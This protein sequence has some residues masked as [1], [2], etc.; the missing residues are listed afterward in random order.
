MPYRYLEALQQQ[1]DELE[2]EIAK[3]GAAC[4]IL[5][6]PLAKVTIIGPDQWMVERRDNYEGICWWTSRT[7]GDKLDALA[8][9]RDCQT[10][11]AAFLLSPQ[12]HP[13]YDAWSGKIEQ[14]R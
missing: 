11:Q 10:V 5:E 8:W 4:V 14:P 3:A 7:T 2:E 9:A 12:S 13:D 1:R 6:L